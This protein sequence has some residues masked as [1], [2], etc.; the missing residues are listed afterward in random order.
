MQ[1]GSRLLPD[2]TEDSELQA[3]EKVMWPPALCRGTLQVGGVV[4]NTTAAS[5]RRQT[6]NR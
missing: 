2:R 4:K 1:D 3:G 5:M 6:T